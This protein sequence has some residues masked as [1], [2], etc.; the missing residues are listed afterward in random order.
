MEVFGNELREN[1]LDN[2]YTYAGYNFIEIYR[3]EEFVLFE[4]TNSNKNFELFRRRKNPVLSNYLPNK[5]QWGSY[6]WTLGSMGSGI[7]KI[8]EI[9]ENY[10]MY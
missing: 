5:S 3:E 10:D 9:K 2:S 6:A 7:N 8:K 4:A 1:W